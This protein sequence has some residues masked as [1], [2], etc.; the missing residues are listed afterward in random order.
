M[1]Q[2]NPLI[3][4]ILTRSMTNAKPRP[5]LSDII[6][7]LSHLIP[8]INQIWHDNF[9][10]LNIASISRGNSFLLHDL[11]KQA[12][13]PPTFIRRANIQSDKVGKFIYSIEKSLEAFRNHRRSGWFWNGASD[14]NWVNWLQLLNLDE[15]S[16]RIDFLRCPQVVWPN[17]I[18]YWTCTSHPDNVIDAR[19]R[20]N[21]SLCSSADALHT[22]ADRLGKLLLHNIYE[23]HRARSSDCIARKFPRFTHVTCSWNY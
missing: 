21:V 22:L 10:S 1:K 14:P 17:E 9:S 15:Q 3:A 19:I 7:A 4:R 5:F 12:C 2:L 20:S 11:F 13:E 18:D 8:P 16:W 6:R 23:H